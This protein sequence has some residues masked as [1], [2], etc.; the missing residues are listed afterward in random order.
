MRLK[1]LLLICIL[2]SS[3]GSGEL[4][5][6]FNKEKFG[7]NR[8]QH[9]NK[10]WYFFASNNFEVYYY[11]GGQRNARMAIDFLES[12]FDDLTQSIGYVA[13]T[14]PKIFIYN[15]KQE[16]LE[17]N[18]N[19]NTNNFT[20]DG[21][22]FFSKLLTEAAYVGSWEEFKKELLY[23][24]SKIIIEEMLYGSSISDAFQ[25][26]LVNN[27]PDWFIDGA[28]KYLA[29][30]WSREMDDF[31]RHYLRENDNPKLFKL[32]NEEAGLVGQSIW[33]YVV[34]KIWEKVYFKHIESKQDQ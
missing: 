1:Y 5:A 4:L 26:N 11:D 20:V 19:L 34:E 6:Q 13:Y 3:L 25:S 17:S 30:G 21:Q 31:V 10:E 16:L 22:T 12:E 15:S 23:K 18:L 24:T 32:Q 9:K 2:F 7:K 8:V 33:N 27:F 29:Y 14:K 28:A